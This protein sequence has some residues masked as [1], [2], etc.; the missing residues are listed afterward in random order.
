MNWFKKFAEFAYDPK[1][2]SMSEAMQRR[3]DMLLCLHCDGALDGIEDSELAIALRISRAELNKTRELFRRKGFIAETWVPRNWDKRQIPADP[4]A[5]ERM[6]RLR[7]RQRN[8]DRNVTRNGPVTQTERY[9]EHYAQQTECYAQP[10]SRAGASAGAPE[11]L[12]GEV[13]EEEEKT[14]L[15]VPKGTD[16]SSF[17]P[18][19]WIPR[20]AWDAWIE[21]R[22]RAKKKPTTRALELAVKRLEKLRADGNDPGEVLDQSVMYG[23]LGLFEVHGK[24]GANGHVAPAPRAK[25]ER[26]LKMER[27]MQ[28]AKEDTDGTG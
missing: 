10:F 14:P 12:E 9:A 15:K 3:L 24:G 23:W 22:V 1:V 11:E 20:E 13:E 28:W 16:L 8:D 19:D 27:V 4:T 21:C 6:R 25:T 26:E 5:A 18:P 7:D 2:Q 17:I